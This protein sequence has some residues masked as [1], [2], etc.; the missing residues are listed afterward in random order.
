MFMKIIGITLFV[1]GAVLFYTAKIW[2]KRFK[3]ADK[4]KVPHEDEYDEAELSGYRD[5]KAQLYVKFAAL[6]VMLPGIVLIV[7]GF[8]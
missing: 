4:M 6:I 2:V 5:T 7:I 3:I 1:L 8:R